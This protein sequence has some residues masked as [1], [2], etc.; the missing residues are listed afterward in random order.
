[1]KNFIKENW[2]KLLL[3]ILVLVVIVIFMSP[4]NKTTNETKKIFSSENV[5]SASSITCT[6][7]QT[8]SA[9]YNSGEISHTLPKPETN[10]M[11]FTFSELNNPKIGQL[12]YID[13]TQSI[14]N[15]SLVK[16]IEDKEKIV[17]A[18]G[19]GEQYLTIHTIYRQIGVSTYTKNVNLLGMIPVVTSAMGSCVGY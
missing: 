3:V 4:L 14:T 11:I 10:P 1:M 5:S 16:L 17:Y 9:S 18:E 2:F 8:L 19:S 7:P 13:S 6:Y 12:S 15:V